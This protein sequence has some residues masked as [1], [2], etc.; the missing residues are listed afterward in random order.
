MAESVETRLRAIE[1][2]PPACERIGVLADAQYRQ[3][4]AK[5][6][7]IDDEFRGF[8][9]PR[10]VAAPGRNFSMAA[11]SRWR[12]ARSTAPGRW[13]EW[14]EMTRR[15][16]V[17]GSAYTY[18]RQVPGRGARAPHEARSHRSRA[19]RSSPASRSRRWK[20][21]AL[22]C[23]RATGRCCSNQRSK[24]KCELEVSFWVL[25]VRAC[26]LVPRRQT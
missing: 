22:S 1:K 11:C 4:N 14:P 18:D 21:R 15:R 8:I 2:F 5:T 19:S 3:L 20:S 7:Q 13:N 10:H 16:P 23:P 12:S 25:W 6:L 24:E 9:R 26:W 17:A